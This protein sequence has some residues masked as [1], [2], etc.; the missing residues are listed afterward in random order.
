MDLSQFWPYLIFLVSALLAIQLFHIQFLV[1]RKSDIQTLAQIKEGHNKQLEQIQILGQAQRNQLQ[2][3]ISELKD[4]QSLLQNTQDYLNSIINSMPSVLI[5]VTDSGEVTHWNS[6]ATFATELLPHEAL[7]KPLQ[8][9]EQWIP[10]S[11]EQVRNAIS[12]GEPIHFKHEVISNGEKRYQDVTIYP[13]LSSS[14]EGAVIRMDDV[15]HQVQLEN[16]MIQNSK[17]VSLGELSA[18]L[19]HELNNPIAAVTQSAQ[20][21]KRR[22]VMSEPNNEDIAAKVGMDWSAYQQYV[23]QRGL[24]KLLTSVETAGA[25]AADI[26]QNMLNYARTVPCEHRPTDV[27]QLIHRTLDILDLEKKGLEVTLNLDLNIPKALIN[28]AEIQQVLIN[29]IHNAEQA[30]EA[31]NQG[32]IKLTTNT[33][34]GQVIIRVKDNGTGIAPGMLDKIFEPFYTTKNHGEGTGL[35]L[36]ISHYIVTEQHAGSLTVCS[37]LDDGTEFTIILPAADTPQKSHSQASEQVEYA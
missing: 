24:I 15:S 23:E 6:S 21:L 17:L 26:V 32:K 1:K 12:A 14:T 4:T 30:F 18:N 22:I 13:L 28:G 29:L 35:G 37:S 16:M 11:L 25:R 7:G 5:G 33:A 20:S 19:I 8:D 9:L 27:N 2:E 10:V 3:S 34:E 36:S 31:H